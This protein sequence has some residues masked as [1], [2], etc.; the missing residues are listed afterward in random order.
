MNLM[1]ARS[2]LQDRIADK[3]ALSIESMGRSSSSHASSVS[4]TFSDAEEVSWILSVRSNGSPEDNQ[5]VHLTTGEQLADVP[6]DDRVHPDFDGWS[7]RT[8]EGVSLTEGKLYR[9]VSTALSE[10]P[11]QTDQPEP[12]SPSP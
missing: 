7:Y 10:P 8:D 11:V 1:D 4:I 5:A 9:A 6:D 2:V 3:P 12:H